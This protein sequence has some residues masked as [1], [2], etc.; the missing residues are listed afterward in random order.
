MIR[1]T[2]ILCAAAM[3]FVT[4]CTNVA[5]REAEISPGMNKHAVTAI[6]GLPMTRSVDGAKEAWQYGHIVGFGQCAYTTIWFSSG[7]VV[8]MTSRRGAS[9][10]GCGLGSHPLDWGQMPH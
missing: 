7:K 3:L 8:G 6:M 2:P 1:Y 10:A 9:V 4:A 5:Q